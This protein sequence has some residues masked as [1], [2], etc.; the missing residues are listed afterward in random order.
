METF[1]VY[2]NSPDTIMNFISTE[3]LY[4]IFREQGRVTTDS[5][6]IQP[7]DI[8][9]ALR[10]ERFDGNEFAAQALADGASYAVIDRKEFKRSDRCLLVPDSLEAL[11]MLAR[12]HRRQFAIPVIGITGSNGKTTTKELMAA[13]LGGHYKLHFTRGNYNNHIGVPLTLLAM[14]ADTEVAVIEMG[15]NAQGEIDALCRIAEPT[16]GLITNIGYAH[17]EGFGGLEG[18]KKGKSELYRYLASTKGVAFI[19][20]D[21]KYLEDLAIMV[22][23]KIFYHDSEQPSPDHIPMEIKCLQLK[24]FIKVAFLSD[25]GRLFEADSQLAGI[26]NL[27]NI[28]TAIAVGKYF[29]VPGAVI[30]RAIAQY[31]PENNRSQWME[32]DGVRYF[33]DAYNANPSSMLASLE[34]FAEQDYPNKTVILGDMLELGEESAA[35]HRRIAERAVDLGLAAVIL[36]GPQFAVAARA[37]GLSHYPDVAALRMVWQQEDHQGA[38][39]MLKG[40]RGMALE[41]L[42]AAGE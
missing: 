28:K 37:L 42:L 41:K 39:V 40:S 15:A 2:P 22:G 18:V 5:R 12:H 9:F 34:T 26:H 6:K 32:K 25:G 3:E 27:Q 17:L 16:H 10:G 38:T 13:V 29:K 36:V 21:E 19:N 1:Y 31:V 8:F 35:A 14:P 23:R 4:A 20:R 11:Q 7:G 33:M 30:V 24:P